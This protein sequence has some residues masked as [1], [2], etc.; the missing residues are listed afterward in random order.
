[1]LYFKLITTLRPL[2]TRCGS[3]KFKKELVKS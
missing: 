2:N 3:S 1:M